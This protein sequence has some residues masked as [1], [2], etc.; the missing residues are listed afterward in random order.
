MKASVDFLHHLMN[1]ALDEARKSASVGEVPVGAIL[2]KNEVI[3]ARAHNLT[4]TT[5]DPSA[6]A[7]QLVMREGAKILGDWRLTGA[8]L[9]ITLEPCTMCAG[10]IKLARVPIVVFGAFDPRA[11]A[12][13]SLYDLLAD[14]RTGPPPRVITD[15]LAAESKK[16]LKDFFE[17]RR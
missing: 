11:G 17:K 2:A 16:L 14:E 10:T 7:E 13:G 5:R 12:V 3:I 9:V 15:V 4:E 6:H 1:A 8:I